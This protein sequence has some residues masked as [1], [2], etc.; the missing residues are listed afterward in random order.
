MRGAL[1]GDFEKSFNDARDLV[2]EEGL[3]A[4]MK[5]KDSEAVKEILEQ[6][7]GSQEKKD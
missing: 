1:P 5:I 6:N 4:A 7:Q 2:R 3:K